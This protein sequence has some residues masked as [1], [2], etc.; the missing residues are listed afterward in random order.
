MDDFIEC[1]IF[2]L[3]SKPVLLSK[4]VPLAGDLCAEQLGLKE[5]DRII[6]LDNVSVV[7]HCAASVRFD[8][9]SK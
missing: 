1:P 4:I 5:E 7:F 6:L 9:P 2:S 8:E 3:C